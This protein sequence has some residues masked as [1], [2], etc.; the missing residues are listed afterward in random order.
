[1]PHPTK[2][3]Y[4]WARHLH[5]DCGIGYEPAVASQ[6]WGPWRVLRL[7]KY[8][9]HKGQNELRLARHDFDYDGAEIDLTDWQW[10]PALTPPPST[11]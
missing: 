5:N 2:P 7:F 11:P 8:T 4:Y 1:M 6:S 3:G 10:G 9:D